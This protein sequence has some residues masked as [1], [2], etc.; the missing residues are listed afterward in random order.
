MLPHCLQVK[1]TCISGTRSN[2]MSAIFAFCARRCNTREGLLVLRR[3]GILPTIS[4]FFR[5][6]FTPS[7]SVYTRRCTGIVEFHL[8]FV[9]FWI[10]SP[11]M[12]N[13]CVTVE[14]IQRN[15]T[16]MSTVSVRFQHKTTR[17]DLNTSWQL[18]LLVDILERC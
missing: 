12:M 10:L 6:K 15:I 3:S 9:S 18:N 17:T 1:K 8:C 13:S 14:L 5:C 2:C 7:V 4:S 11:I 16:A